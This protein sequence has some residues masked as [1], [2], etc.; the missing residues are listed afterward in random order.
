VTTA[1]KW[2]LG[3]PGVGF[4][5]LSPELLEG[6][7]V[8]DVGYL[9]LDAALG[10]WPPH[11]LPGIVRDARR[12]ELG[13][14]NLPGMVAARAG[15]DLLMD[16]GVERIFAHVQGLVT[17]WMEGLAERGWRLVTPADPAARAGV[18][19]FEHPDGLGLFGYLR[20]RGVDIGLLVPPGVRV[21]PH[22]FNDA[23]D[24][25]RFLDGLDIFSRS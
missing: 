6:S 1:M 19:V 13:L 11:T 7:P 17:A 4:L 2:L 8:L 16:V 15:I 9:G 25:E 22:G 18:I 12:F 24:I 5:Y 10:D 3:P 14:P 21:D 20:E 23:A